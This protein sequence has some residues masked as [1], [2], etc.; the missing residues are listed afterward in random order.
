MKIT[1]MAWRLRY[2]PCQVT[3]NRRMA[4]ATISAML[5]PMVMTPFSHQRQRADSPRQGEVPRAG[6]EQRE[7]IR[8]DAP[9]RRPRGTA[10]PAP[11]REETTLDRDRQQL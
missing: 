4:P 2:L 6:H 8:G 1:P 9:S 3:A 5:P 10:S 7:R 11:G